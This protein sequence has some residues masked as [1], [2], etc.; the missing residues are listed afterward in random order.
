MHLSDIEACN[1]PSGRALGVNT[2][3]ELVEVLAKLH[4]AAQVEIGCRRDG[5]FVEHVFDEA[6]DDLEE[7][8]GASC[9]RRVFVDGSKFLEAGF[10]VVNGLGGFG[11]GGPVGADFFEEGGCG[12]CW[13]RC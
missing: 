9:L 8:A 1:L 7:L 3:R 2:L 4:R 13:G 6:D 5:E 11:V 12:C 10:L